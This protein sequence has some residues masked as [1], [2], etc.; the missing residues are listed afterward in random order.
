MLEL[1]AGARDNGVRDWRRDSKHGRSTMQGLSGPGWGCQFIPRVGME[2]VVAFDGGD[3]DKP[4]VLG[5]VYNGTHPAP[6]NVP[7]GKTRSGIR[8]SS[9]P[10]GQGSNELSFE[11]AAGAEQVFLHAQRDLDAA[12][13]RDRTA[14][15]K[16][17][18]VEEIDRH[19]KSTVGGDSTDLVKGKREDRVLG[20]ASSEIVG[21]RIDVVSGTEDRRV[22]GQRTLRLESGDMVDVGGA[23]EHHYARDLTTRVTGNH[24]IIVGKHDARRSLTL[25]IEGT[26]TISTEDGLVIE[27][28]GGLTMKCG[29]TSIRVGADGIELHG[30]MVRAA[31]DAGGLEV[32]KDGLKLKSEG[33][34][35]HFGE[36]LLVKSEKA[37]LAMGSE[38][39]IDGEKILLNSPENAT[40]KPPTEPPP[41]TEIDLVDHDGKPLAGQ[42]F[43][44]LLDDGSQ[45]TGVTDKDGKAKLDLPCGGNIR[46]PALSE[47][48]PG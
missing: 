46:F 33:V 39:K 3:P 10:G 24:T 43:V 27:A 19:R 4:I 28:K 23:A 6:F 2:V 37:S 26:G 35:A 38:V 8:T 13:E 31:G 25:R 34:L 48:E 42:R 14:R 47:V 20:D 9:S 15:V 30:T 7:E 16:R 45:R 32:G 12:V 29:T 41:P 18:D 1:H 44:V 11:D 40:D 36:K 22:R 17:D 5:T 21:N